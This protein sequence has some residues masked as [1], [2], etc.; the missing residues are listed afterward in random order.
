MDLAVSPQWTSRE[1]LDAALRLLNHAN[2]I[3]HR[4]EG[5]IFG[6]SAGCEAL[7]GWTRQE[8]V[9]KVIHQLLSTR[10]P[11]PRE[12]ICAEV[13]SAGVWEGEILHKHKDGHTV[14]SA[15]RWVALRIPD[16]P[17]PII[18]QTNNDVTN[19]KATEINLAER[20]AHLRSIL[21]TVPDSM[22]VIEE[23][24]TITSFSAAAE[25][26]FGYSAG[27]VRGRNVKMLMPSPDREKHDGY[28]N[29]YITTGERRI[30]GYGRVVTG[31]RKDGTLFPMELAVGETRV[32]GKRIFTGFVRDLTSRHKIEEELRQ[33]QKMEAIG[34]LTGGLAHDFNNLLTVISGNLE[35]IESRLND[36]KLL[37]MLREAQGAAED[38]A[39]LTGQLLAFGRKQP[40][41]PKIVDVGQLV[42]GF[43]DL[44]RRSVGEMIE[45]RT[46]ISGGSNE[47]LVDASQLQN[48]I[49]N[50]TL[51][52]RDAM[53]R[54]G[55]LSIEISR[56][57]LDVDY[58][59]M[60]PHVRTGDYVL[61]SVT[62]N[63]AG[64]SQEVKQRAFEP[65]FTTK[66]VG[67]GT[68]LGLSMVYGFAKQSGGHIQLY[69]EEG[70]GTSV[71]VFLPAV[72]YAT[73]MASPAE[74]V[75]VKRALPGGSEKILAVEDD[76]R[77]R[78][79]AVSRLI[80]LGYEVIEAENGAAA[81]ERLKQ[82]SDIALLF[83]DVVMPGGMTGDELAEIVRRERPEIKV[84][85]TSGYAEPEIAG[86]EL[87]ASGSWLKKPY[88][89]RELA[90]RLRELLD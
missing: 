48:A 65:F 16:E 17:E 23:N 21:D 10:F 19:M 4:L 53:P 51:N 25:R 67:A 26:L 5:T 27:E 34:Q 40:L 31:Q 90:E 29:R 78:R 42:S 11:K 73:D 3:V 20:E 59:Q 70:Q 1:D 45:L 43:S 54:G 14:V 47:A 66:S 64:M 84:L 88:T 15:T 37:T 24:G 72:Q 36:E 57:K 30:I 7:Y 86:R 83:T 6:W 32:N 56:V 39:K 9:G 35:M 74:Q 55:R 71:R 69:S 63:G 61:V 76:A 85:F 41:N 80:D 12:E 52:A 58:A 44:L 68:G 89:A 28:L 38:G 81:L 77:V 75:A 82:H 60:Y 49:L 22:I 79:V 46:I 33:A 2:L 87:A 8:A 13:L 18:I 62:D 50:L